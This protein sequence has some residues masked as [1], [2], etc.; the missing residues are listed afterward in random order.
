VKQPDP[1]RSYE[2]FNY[3]LRPS[4]QVERKLF[5]EIL[6]ALKS[7]DYPI[8]D[9]TYLGFGSIFYADFILFHKYLY[10]DKMVCV[11]RDPIERRMKFNKP[12]G[13][14]KLFMRSASELIP[15]IRRNTRYIVWLDYDRPLDSE[16]LQDIDGFIQ[17]LAPGSIL[18]ATVE[19][20]PRLTTEGFDDLSA[21][22]RS[23]ELLK[24]YSREFSSLVRHEIRAPN[25]TRN[26]L[27]KL[28]SRILI[29]QVSRSLL[30]R[31]GLD[32]IQLFNFCYAD[33]AQM[34][35]LGG[36]IDRP[37]AARRRPLQ[38][39]FRHAHVRTSE[40]PEVISVPPLTVR[41]K[42]W[43]DTNSLRP[44]AARARRLDLDEKLMKNYEKYYRHYPTYFES[45]I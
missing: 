41:E 33:G 24:L 38:R 43:I 34:L 28:V 22:D 7:D 35:T 11:E 25:L 14:I 9:Y 36:I 45:M 40:E 42:H 16:L 37:A 4:K 1:V 6:H 31:K 20:E 5:I 15:R 10:I 8:Q 18:L 23:R 21:K 3:L 29:G 17:V 39:L 44:I 32:F 27:P 13:F 2:K 30:S 26:E 12:F 19:A